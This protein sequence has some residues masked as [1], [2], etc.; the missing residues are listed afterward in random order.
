[1]TGRSLGTKDPVGAEDERRTLTT[2][3][4]AKSS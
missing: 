2:V 4:P 3:G 1:M